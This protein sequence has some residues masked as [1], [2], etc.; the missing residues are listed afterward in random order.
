MILSISLDFCTREKNLLETRRLLNTEEVLSFL[1]IKHFIK[2]PLPSDLIV[3]EM[4]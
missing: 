3:W 1:N 4:S 2:T